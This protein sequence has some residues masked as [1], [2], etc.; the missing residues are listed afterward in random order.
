[1]RE[2]AP[3]KVR[4]KR[5]WMEASTSWGVLLKHRGLLVLPFTSFVLGSAGWIGGY[6]LAGVWVERTMPR[7]ALTSFIVLVPA[8]MLGTFLSAAFLAALSR[9]LESEPASVADG[10]R[11]AWRRR[12]PIAAWALL[13]AGFGA[14]LQALQQFKS[15]WALAPVISALAGVAWGVLTVFVLPVLALEDLGVRDT[16]RRAAGIVRDRWGESVAGLGNLTLVNVVV[17]LPLALALGVA[18]G[19]AAP[20]RDA[21]T[22]IFVVGFVAFMLLVSAIGTAGQ[23]LSLALYRHATGRPA[24]PFTESEL[25]QALVP[26]RT[27]WRRRG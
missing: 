10:L 8:T 21:V 16:I 20:D 9:R 11:V 26:R 12:G 3:L 5:G 15:E 17:M 1:M 25:E 22:A 13:A 2:R 27:F 6:L 23:V 24:R 7:L 19:V 14:L 4:L 18:A